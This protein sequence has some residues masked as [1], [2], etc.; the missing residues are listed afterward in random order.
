MNLSRTKKMG[1]II[2]LLAVLRGQ[3]LFNFFRLE[4]NLKDIRW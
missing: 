4:Q 2:F 1:W 3:G